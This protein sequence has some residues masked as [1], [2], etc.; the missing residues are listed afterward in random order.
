MKP[1]IAT[2]LDWAGVT[3]AGLAM[4]RKSGP[5]IRAVNYHDVP[6]GEARNFERHLEFFKEHF[7]PVDEAVLAQHLQGAWRSS[8]PGLII[9]FDDGLRSHHSVAAPI[10]LAHGWKGWFFVPTGFAD[11]PAERQEVVSKAARITAQTSPA[12]GRIFLTWQEIRELDAYHI[13]G[14]HTRSHRRLS[15][16]LTVETLDVE[17]R[18]SKATLER[19]LGHDVD[20]FAWV[21]GE[22]YSYSAEA[23]HAIRGARYRYAFMTNNEIIRPF[24]N[25]LQLQRTNLESHMPLELVRFQLSGLLDLAYTGKRA[26]VNKLTS[27][28]AA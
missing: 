4:Q 2:S 14:C 22:E 17:I 20:S 27:A 28:P 16:D 25:P 10:L 15:P 18:E 1:A 6:A 23:A 7:A 21:G 5:F 12:D 8:K 11:V 3:R 19:Q 9:T 24:A 26:R 13:V